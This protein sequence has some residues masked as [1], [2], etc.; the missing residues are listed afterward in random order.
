MDP[1][2]VTQTE[3]A[4]KAVQGQGEVATRTAPLPDKERRSWT[5]RQSTATIDVVGDVLLKLGLV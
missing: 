2:P 1:K 3:I 4:Q 5:R